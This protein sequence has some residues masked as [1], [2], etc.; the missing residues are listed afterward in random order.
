MTVSDLA[1]AQQT[2]GPRWQSRASWTGSLTYLN[3]VRQLGSSSFS[4]STAQLDEA[5][6]NSILGRPAYEVTDMS[7]ALST[8]ANTAFVYGDFS[9]YVIVDKVGVPAST[10]CR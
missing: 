10:T 6:S 9:H 4:S 1:D 2:L 5:I 7:T 8:V 3:R